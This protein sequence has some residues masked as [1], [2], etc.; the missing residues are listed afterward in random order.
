[1]W[2][3]CTRKHKFFPSSTRISSTFNSSRGCR[4]P[5]WHNN[6]HRSC[7]MGSILALIGIGRL[8]SPID[9]TTMLSLP[10]ELLP[11]RYCLLS[12]LSWNV[13]MRSELSM[14]EGGMPRN[15]GIL[16]KMTRIRH[17][18]LMA[19]KESSLEREHFWRLGQCFRS[20]V[21]ADEL[22]SKSLHSVM[23]F[24]QGMGMPNCPNTSGSF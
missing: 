12:I 14:Q 8:R 6:P 22:C 20:F 5:M 21:H 3:Y 19:N 17:S 2:V 9:P 18:V 10:S 16:A 7:G 15:G 13:R 11:A 4:I 23:N 24:W 1:M